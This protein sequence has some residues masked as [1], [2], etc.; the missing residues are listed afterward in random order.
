VA[1]RR[2]TLLRALIARELR[3]RGLVW[4]EIALR[5]HLS[6]RGSVKTMLTRVSRWERTVG[7]SADDEVGRY[8]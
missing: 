5:L 8:R 3:A 2:R 4:R 1:P 7:R 6:A